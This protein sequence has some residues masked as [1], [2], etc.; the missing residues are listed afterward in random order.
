MEIQF[1]L[2]LSLQEN[3]LAVFSSLRQLCIQTTKSKGYIHPVFIALLS[4]VT[5]LWEQP[6]CLSIDEWVKTRWYIYT[7]EY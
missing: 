2:N 4:T 3:P 6:K 7:M 1:Y 5:K